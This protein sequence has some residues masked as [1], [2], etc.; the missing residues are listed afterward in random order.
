MVSECW[1]VLQFLDIR[2]LVADVIATR[3][4]LCL[5]I[6]WCCQYCFIWQMFLPL[7]YIYWQMLLPCI[8]GWCYCHSCCITR[9]A[10][11]IANVAVGIATCGII[12]SFGR[13]YCHICWLM[14]YHTYMLLCFGWCYCHFGWWY[15][16]FLMWLADVIAKVA[17]GIAYL[18]GWCG[19][20]YNHRWQME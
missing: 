3:Q 20:C 19:R 10:D 12:V 6:G 17:D 14:F 16:H 11:V 2:W 9:L 18:G 7:L 4:V 15:C 8:V 5:Y 13:C 1:Y